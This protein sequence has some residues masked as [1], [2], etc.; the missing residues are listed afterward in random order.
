MSQYIHNLA[1]LN[2]HS[3]GVSGPQSVP[4]PLTAYTSSNG[5]GIHS[6]HNQYFHNPQIRHSNALKFI[7]VTSIF[8]LII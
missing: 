5:G 7:S 4:T 1:P 8:S 6:A 3:S 2:P